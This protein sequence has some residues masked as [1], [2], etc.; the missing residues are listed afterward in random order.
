MSSFLNISRKSTKNVA[1]RGDFLMRREKKG[2]VK[3]AYGRY[4]VLVFAYNDG[5]PL[6]DI[7]M[8]FF[9]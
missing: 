3:N 2:E 7:F 5:L 9:L 8:H 4:A 6:F 1:V